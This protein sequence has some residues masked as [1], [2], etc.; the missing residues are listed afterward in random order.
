MI[1]ARM[2]SEVT[3]AE[4]LDVMDISFSLLFFS[5]VI[6]L[7]ARPGVVRLVNMPWGYRWSLQSRM[8]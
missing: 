2:M 6:F 3:G 4:H 1:D 7:A 8:G 5:R